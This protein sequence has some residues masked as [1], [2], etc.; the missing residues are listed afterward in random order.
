MHISG[1]RNWHRGSYFVWLIKAILV[2]V[3]AC[4]SWWYAPMSQTDLSQ[5]E[6]RVDA[7]LAAFQRLKVENKTLRD[8]Y[9]ALTRKNSETRHRLQS[10]IERIKALEEEAE[11]QQA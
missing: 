7:M 9:A 10:V 3:N 4:Q 1:V 5:L 8:E 6:S 11:A 2:L